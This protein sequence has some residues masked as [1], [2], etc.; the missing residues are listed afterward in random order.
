MSAF[1]KRSAL[2]GIPS[3]AKYVLL[4][5]VALSVAGCSSLP[6]SD[7][8]SGDDNE[9]AEIEDVPDVPADKILNAGIRQMN[10]GDPKKAQKAFAEIEKQHPF[11]QE[12]QRSLVLSAFTHFEEGE[13]DETVAKATRFLQLYPGNKD[14]A[15]MQFL[16]AESYFNQVNNVSLDQSDTQ[17]GIQAYE[18]LV[19]LYPDS[20]YTEA[21]KR[22]LVF[23]KDQMAGKEMEIGR[24]YQERSQHLAAVNRFQTVAQS[25]QTTR[26]VEEALYRMTESYLA[27]GVASEAQTAAALLGYNYPD[28][29]WYRDAFGLLTG[30]NL[31]PEVNRSSRLTRFIPFVGDDDDGNRNTR[32]SSPSVNAVP[33]SIN[34]DPIQA[35]AQSTRA[36]GLEEANVNSQVPAAAADA[37]DGAVDGASEAAASAAQSAVPGAA[38]GEAL[39][40]AQA[41][42]ASAVE[43]E[44]E[45]K[46]GI[47]RF[48]PFVG[49]KKDDDI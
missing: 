16:I 17:K 37:V 19:R 46:S 26:H 2:D 5:G 27:L 25:F 3:L 9:T 6:F 42:V 40:A 10:L 4:A 11:S 41:P 18:D 15:Y 1:S 12:A 20:E 49:D 22:K 30:K 38:D 13:Y 45:K 44:P 39:P 36:P 34:A 23:M 21:S 33:A 7:R 14:S 48:I 29:Q 47:R 32:R 43:P 31:Q 28:S 35:A 24:Y 8:F